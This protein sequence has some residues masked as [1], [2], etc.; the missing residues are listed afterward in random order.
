MLMRLESFHNTVSLILEELGA[1]ADPG[2]SLSWSF[3]NNSTEIIVRD[4]PLAH[5]IEFRHDDDGMVI[6]G[7]KYM[8]VWDDDKQMRAAFQPLKGERL[9]KPHELSTSRLREIITN[10]Y[11]GVLEDWYIPTEKQGEVFRVIQRAATRSPM[12]FKEQNQFEND[13]FLFYAEPREKING[14][15]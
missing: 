7:R 5:R 13:L 4:F 6:R 9:P 15:Q 2:N 1:F 8:A 12:T 14:S 3:E 11:L 10:Y